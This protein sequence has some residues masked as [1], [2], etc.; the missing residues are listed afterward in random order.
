MAYLYDLQLIRIE[1]LAAA[2]DAAQAI[3]GA[4]LFKATAPVSALRA[5]ED[6]NVSLF[7]D[8]Y[9]DRHIF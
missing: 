3:Y 5:D 9:F 4:T 6:V 1:R 2:A 8:L 7:V